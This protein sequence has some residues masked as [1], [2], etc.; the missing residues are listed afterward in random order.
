MLEEARSSGA[1]ERMG[2]AGL[3]LLGGTVGRFPAAGQGS[4]KPHVWLVSSPWQRQGR[5][6]R[7]G[8][9]RWDTDQSDMPVPHKAQTR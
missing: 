1:A 5:R 2:E 7:D 3:S 9:Q 6:Q 8:V 4:T